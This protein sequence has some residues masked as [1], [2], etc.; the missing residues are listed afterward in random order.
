MSEDRPPPP[1]TPVS[2]AVIA[3]AQAELVRALARLIARNWRDR[4]AALQGDPP[5][6]NPPEPPPA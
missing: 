3:R 4:Q 5:P 2:P 1:A 6:K